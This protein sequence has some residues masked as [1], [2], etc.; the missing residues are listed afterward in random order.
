MAVKAVVLKIIHTDR[1]LNFRVLAFTRFNNKEAVVLCCD[2]LIGIQNAGIVE[3]EAS[4]D[5]GNRVVYMLHAV[6]RCFVEQAVN[7][8]TIFVFWIEQNRRLVISS[9]NV[10]FRIDLDAVDIDLR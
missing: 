2:F 3:T 6:M 10:R 7:Q 5:V 4:L 1:A 9:G 8:G